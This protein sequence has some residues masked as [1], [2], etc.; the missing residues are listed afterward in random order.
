M[1]VFEQNHVRLVLDGKFF[2]R[3]RQR[4]TRCAIEQLTVGFGSVT[5]LTISSRAMLVLVVEASS[6]FCC[7]SD[8]KFICW[9]GIFV[10]SE[11]VRKCCCRIA[12]YK[13]HS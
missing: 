10:R 3:D 12:E 5:V 8:I 11:M 2:E 13:L 6:L 4:V 7:S 9:M 1:A